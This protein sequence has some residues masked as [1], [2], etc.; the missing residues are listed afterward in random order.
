LFTPPSL[1]GTVQR[2]GLIGGA[3]WGGGAF[4][5]RTGVL[6]FKTSNQ[7]TIARVG[8]PDRSSANP[9]AS[10]VDADITRIGETSAEFMN[11]LP[12]L[13]PPYG[14][15]V[16]LDLN[17]AAI[18]WRVPFGDMPALRHHPALKDVKLPAVLGVPG[19]PGV[20]ATAGGLVFAGGGDAAF[21]A[22]DA[23]TGHDVWQFPLTRRANG[24]PMTYRSRAGRQFVVVATGGGEDAALVGFAIQKD[25]KDTKKQS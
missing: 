16:A 10:E 6:F 22:V 23:A 15:L 14:H 3:N 13:K 9:R 2:P 8:K 19:A 11:G 5:A 21:H 12:L 1:R 7:A 24:T 25:T 17:R 4:D 18:K 20:L